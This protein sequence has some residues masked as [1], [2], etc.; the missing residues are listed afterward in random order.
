M[1]STPF[2]SSASAQAGSLSLEDLVHVQTQRAF[3]QFKK[4][5]SR[6][7]GFHIG[8][9]ILGCLELLAFALFFA[10]LTQTTMLAFSLAAILLTGFSYAVILFYLQGK[11]P[12]QLLEIREA[13]VREVRASLS[14]HSFESHQVIIQALYH[15]FYFLHRK[16]YTYYS[17]PALFQTLSLLVQKFGVWCHFEARH[18]MQEALLQ[19]IIQEH[20]QMVKLAPTDFNTHAGLAAAYT[21]L[22]QHYQD[23]RHT[24]PS[25]L[26]L[27]ISPEY[28]GP[29][30]RVQ[31]E[32]AAKK[33]IEEYRILDEYAP[34]DPWIHAQLAALFHELE[35]VVEEIQ[36]Y[37]T[38]LS[39]SPP[40]PDVLLRLGILYFTQGKN[41]QALRLYEQLMDRHPEYA[42]Q[43]LSHYN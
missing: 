11:K 4:V 33:A 38:L 10:F 26:H 17:L 37:E 15:L 43:L 13:F 23:P 24:E 29:R 31:F 2:Y 3:A 35:M 30:M 8:F 22:S 12:E 14:P 40:E 18:Q 7:A 39:L 21:H 34:H 20:I 42:S 41:A 5:T 16:E 32:K 9:F 19:M 28:H 1:S 25:E 27:W 6:Y 36:T